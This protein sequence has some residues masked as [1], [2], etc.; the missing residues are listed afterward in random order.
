M[1]ENKLDIKKEI[2]SF[3]KTLVLSFLAVYLFNTFILRPVRVQ[4]DSMYPNLKDKEYGLSSVFNLRTEGIN[5]FD[6]VIVYVPE[7]KD[8]LVKRVIGLPNETISFKNNELYVN[9]ELVE[10]TFLDK[11]KYITNDFEVLVP[12]GSYF[13]MGDNRPV[14][15]DSR[16]YGSFKT[17]QI[18]CKDV[19]LIYPF[20]EI[21]R[22]VE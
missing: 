17:D 10:E 13:C 8:Y 14:S 18:K 11:E 5:R 20:S 16:Y 4:G 9:N 19:Y 6:V 21:G 2:I 15:K 12:E 7:T 22:K 3:I 1:E